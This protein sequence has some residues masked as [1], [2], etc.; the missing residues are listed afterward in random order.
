MAAELWH[1][2]PEASPTLCCGLPLLQVALLGALSPGPGNAEQRLAP[3]G[4]RPFRR[5]AGLGMRTV[6]CL[7]TATSEEGLDR[8]LLAAVACTV[9]PPRAGAL[10]LACELLVLNFCF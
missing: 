2:E 10:L 5:F 3:Q 1:P 7:S 6:S 9:P 4:E 8:F